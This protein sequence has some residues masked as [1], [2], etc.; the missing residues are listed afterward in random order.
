MTTRTGGRWLAVCL[1]V[2]LLV[3]VDGATRPA[4]SES[5][6]APGETLHLVDATGAIVGPVL[7][8]H[9]AFPPFSGP[10]LAG[11]VV[12]VAVR[13]GDRVL[14]LWA[15]R[16]RFLTIPL[17]PLSFPFRVAFEGLGCTGNRFIE[18]LFDQPAYAERLVP[19]YAIGPGQRLYLASGAAPQAL[20]AATVFDESVGAC[21][22]GGA[23]T[24]LPA[25]E[26]ADLDE[27]F[28]PP[29]HVE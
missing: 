3:G 4:A 7:Q 28:P 14:T 11:P 24:A 23:L 1:V 29:Y 9:R 21:A 16:H 26:V 6:P 2:G 27:L 13:V 10:S 20:A 8:T 18:G 19:F 5:R 15:S 25:I 22:V 17:A 12:Q